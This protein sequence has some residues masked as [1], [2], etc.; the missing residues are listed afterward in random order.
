MDPVRF[1]EIFHR[2]GGGGGGGGDL[3]GGGEADGLMRALCEGL[4]VGEEDCARF[5]LYGVAYWQGGRCPEWVAHITRCADLSCFATYLLTCH[6]SG[7]CEFTGGRVARDRLPSLRE[8]V[9]VL[10]SLFLAFTLV[11]FKSMRVG[12]EAA[13]GAFRRM[14]RDVHWNLLLTLG[15]DKAAPAFMAAAGLGEYS[16]PL[17]RCNN[18]MLNVL[19]GMKRK[20]RN[21]FQN[22]TPLS[23]PA[24]HLRLE[25]RCMFL[26]EG[27]AEAPL[28]DHDLSFLKAL[29]D[30]GRTV[31]C[32][33]PFNAMVGALAFQSMAASRYVVLPNTTDIKS[34]TAHDLYSKIIGYNILCPFLSVP[35]HRGY[36]GGD[37]AGARL[38]VVCAE[39]GYCLNLGKG[40]FSKVSFN[41]THIFYCRDQ[42]EKYLTTCAS[43]GRIYC[44]FCGSC[45][46]RTYPLKFTVGNRQYIRAV[47]A[48]NC[49][50]VV[51]D[52]ATELDLV[53]P[54]LGD[55]CTQVLLR[56]VA[57]C[58]LFYLTEPGP[59]LYCS[60]CLKPAS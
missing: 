39:C 2:L 26:R 34:F 36:R 45:R 10:Q 51:S 59:G 60:R 49:S 43:T 11:I 38:A 56:R 12:V 31:P 25:P 47:G 54:C 41:P 58:D 53:L 3:F 1:P 16:L 57:V 17:V 6:R 32:G 46:I 18:N 24:P 42:K 8:S 33:N 27:R 50:I 13:G 29:R 14:A 35:V 15:L 28:S 4:R 55:D 30:G 19:V 23:V 48:S 40:K 44:S 52:S 7:G 20:S 21:H 5:V 37:G 9:E 22:D